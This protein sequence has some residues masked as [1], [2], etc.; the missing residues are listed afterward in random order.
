MSR[1][2][3]PSQHSLVR[4][5]V[6]HVCYWYWYDASLEKENR[7][8]IYIQPSTAAWFNR[9]IQSG[10]VLYVSERTRKQWVRAAKPTL[11]D[12]HVVTSAP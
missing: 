1:F 9:S 7:V 4:I 3:V 12:R 6:G 8:G 10:N 5:A 11:R 2:C